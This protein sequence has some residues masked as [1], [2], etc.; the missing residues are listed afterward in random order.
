VGPFINQQILPDI[1]KL[2]ASGEPLQQ[3]AAALACSQSTM[4]E[5]AALVDGH[6]DLAKRIQ[7]GE[8]TWE[9]F[10]KQLPVQ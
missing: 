5:A 3:M 10:S 8:L 6:P 7:S 4:P 2:F 1:E 9:S